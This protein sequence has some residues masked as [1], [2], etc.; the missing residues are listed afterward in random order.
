MAAR[1]DCYT[2]EEK[3]EIAAHVLV[4]ASCGRFVTR[5]FREDKTTE[6]GVKMPAEST[7]WRW[8][9][10]DATGELEEKLTEARA[11]GVE[12][13]L[14]QTL[15]IADDGRNDTYLKELDSGK[16]IEV[17]DV[18]VIQRSKLRVETRIKLAQMLKPKKYGPKLDLTSGGEKLGLAGELEA[19]RKRAAGGE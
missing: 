17:T 1:K 15:D 8:V 12:A 10:E 14:D 4:N 5:T 19:A 7:F 6:N 18:D 3:A 13:L 9:L 11:R 16:E 2:D